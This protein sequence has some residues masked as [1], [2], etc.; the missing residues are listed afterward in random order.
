MPEKLVYRSVIRSKWDGEDQIV[1]QS[2]ADGL[3]YSSGIA[4]NVSM[5][6]LTWLYN[7]AYFGRIDWRL[8]LDSLYGKVYPKAILEI[9]DS[10]LFQSRF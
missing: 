10:L 8:P 4:F 9:R 7:Y 3:K 5:V 2:V 1:Y 6:P